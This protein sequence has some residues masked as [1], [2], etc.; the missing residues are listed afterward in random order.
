MKSI[1]GILLIM[2]SL[3]M[4]D[5]DCLSNFAIC[6]VAGWIGYN[7]FLIIGVLIIYYNSTSKW[8]IV[9]YVII[10]TLLSNGYKPLNEISEALIM[11]SFLA[12]GIW[13]LVKAVLNLI[14]IIKH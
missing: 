8:T 9:L 14:S 3:W 2:S 4:H 10:L 13:L 5:T 12:M 6:D 7:A 11:N 1:L